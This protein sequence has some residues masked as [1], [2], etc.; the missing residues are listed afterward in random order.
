[1][2][3]NGMIYYQTQYWDTQ[4]VVLFSTIHN[5]KIIGSGKLYWF[6]KVP[7]KAVICNLY[8]N[9]GYRQ[10]GKGKELFFYMEEYAKTK[11]CESIS[12]WVDNGTWL[13]KWYKLSG[14][15]FSGK[16]DV[17]VSWLVKDVK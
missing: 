11:G 6:N 17:G 7:K 9:I 8:V 13:E 5:D 2:T 14:Y 1:M 4:L 16:K 15:T 10:K 3:D 12:L